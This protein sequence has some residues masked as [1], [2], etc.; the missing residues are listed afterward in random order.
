M[1]TRPSLSEGPSEDW[2][3]R[4]SAEQTT[5]SLSAAFPP[6]SSERR[7]GAHGPPL[8]HLP[9]KTTRGGG[10]FERAASSAPRGQ[11]HSGERVENKLVVKLK[12]SGPMT[13]RMRRDV[14]EVQADP[15]CAET[16]I[17]DLCRFR[18]VTFFGA[19]S[20]TAQTVEYT[21]NYR[22]PDEGVL[23][24]TCGG[25]EA[26]AVFDKE[27]VLQ[28]RD[29]DATTSI[30]RT[31]TCFWYCTDYRFQSLETSVDASS[32]YTDTATPFNFASIY[33]RARDPNRRCS[34]RPR[35]KGC[36]AE[37][38]SRRARTSSPSP[39]PRA[40]TLTWRTDRQ[41]S[42]CRA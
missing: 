29:T 39:T 18:D 14:A 7:C 25:I 34:K 6:I 17:T 8:A 33:E 35:L 9:V 42:T 36:S 3:S 15:T 28:C 19:P 32:F 11:M 23:A 37:F 38:G 5:R 1:N 16:H 21:M 10:L 30:A 24:M 22:N 27:R 41:A 26:K 13:S 4:R 31:S 40:S 12:P 20:G 2:S